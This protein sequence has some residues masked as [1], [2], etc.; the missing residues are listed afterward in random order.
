MCIYVTVEKIQVSLQD[1]QYCKEKPPWPNGFYDQ[2]CEWLLGPQE[3]DSLNNTASNISKK[4][5]LQLVRNINAKVTEYAPLVFSHIRYQDGLS[6]SEIANSL[7]ELF[8]KDIKDSI[9]PY[10][11]DQKALYS[12]DKRFVI[13]L[14]PEDDRVNLVENIL[15]K[16]HEHLTKSSNKSLLSRILGIYTVFSKETFDILLLQNFYPPEIQPLATFELKGTKLH[17]QVLCDSSIA[18]AWEVSQNLIL[19]DLDFFQVQQFILVSFLDQS[20]LGRV[21]PQDVSFLKEMQTL[22]Y[23]LFVGVTNNAAV[24]KH[25]LPSRYSRHIYLGK[26]VQSSQVFVVGLVDFFKQSL[27]TNSSC[28]EVCPQDY[29]KRFLNFAL[30][31][32]K[33]D[34]L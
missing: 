11:G 16:Y 14:I 20:W 19:K 13:K 4:S 12:Q 15:P 27:D 32:V 30:S 24:K 25:S 33:C 10:L 2:R 9:R 5:N 34:F 8:G 29:S 7:L 31:I 6:N 28:F 23:S 3:F 17:R 22:D 26:G 1:T 18:S 21:I